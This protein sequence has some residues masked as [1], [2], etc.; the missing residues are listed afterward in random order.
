M[1]EGGEYSVG[2][3]PNVVGVEM[4]LVGMKSVER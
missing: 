4:G 3:E 1:K 2:F